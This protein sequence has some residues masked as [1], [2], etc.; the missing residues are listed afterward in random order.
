MN[1]PGKSDKPIVARQGPGPCE[2]PANQ[3]EAEGL[4]ETVS[5]WDLWEQVQS[6][7]LTKETEEG[8]GP[9]QSEPAEQP[10]GTQCPVRTA[11]AGPEGLPNALDRIRQAEQRLAAILQGKSPVR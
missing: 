5:F 4:P 1:D 2:K 11:Q 6:R 8:K 10:E 7:G 3:P 9:P